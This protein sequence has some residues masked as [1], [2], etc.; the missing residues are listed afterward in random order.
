MRWPPDEAPPGW[1]DA[2]RRWFT[3]NLAR[4]GGAGVAGALLILALIA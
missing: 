3:L 4:L 1:Q 2:R